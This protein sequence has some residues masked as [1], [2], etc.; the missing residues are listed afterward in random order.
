MGH[1][2]RIPESSISAALH[3]RSQ[4]PFT[5]VLAALIGALPDPKA[6]KFFANRY[7]HKWAQAVATFARL[8][9]YHEKIEVK[10]NIALDFSGMS[11][12]ELI[13]R[14]ARLEGRVP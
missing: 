4:K 6:I 10:G 5:D 11:D 14:L 9:G 3:A 1:P 12:V 7:P 2:V 13:E 8:A